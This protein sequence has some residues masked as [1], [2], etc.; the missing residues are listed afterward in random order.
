MDWL[1]EQGIV[2]ARREGLIVYYSLDPEH[3]AHKSIKRLL[4]KIAKSWPDLVDAAPLNDHIKPARRKTI[5]RNARK[6]RAKRPV[7]P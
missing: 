2:R 3:L 1:L 6:R 7:K 4:D 5:D